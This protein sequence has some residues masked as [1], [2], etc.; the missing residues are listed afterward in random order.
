MPAWTSVSR[1]GSTAVE[2]S[3]QTTKSGRGCSPAATAS[4]RSSVSRTWLAVTSR[5]TAGTLRPVPGTSPCTA[6]TVAVPLR[7]SG[8]G[9][10]AGARVTTASPATT[11]YVARVGERTCST[12]HASVVPVSATRKLTPVMP[13]H[14]RASAHG[15][16]AVA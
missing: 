8:N 5:W 4:A 3:G 6:A 7:S 2:F 10:S 11:A 12:S 16:S 1:N 13:I 15:V 9:T 14:G